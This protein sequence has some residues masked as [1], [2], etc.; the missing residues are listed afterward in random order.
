MSWLG[1]SLSDY[2]SPSAPVLYSL[3]AHRRV[4]SEAVPGA[5]FDSELEG[6]VTGVVQQWG[7]VTKTN[8]VVLLV[9]I[10]SLAIRGTSA[11][12]L[13]G[14]YEDFLDAR[15]AEGR[16]VVPVTITP[17]G[18]YVS[19][20]AG[21]KAD[22]LT[23]NAALL[24][25]C[26]ANPSVSSCVDLYSLMDDGTGALKAAYDSGDHVHFTQAGYALYAQS[27]LTAAR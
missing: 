18:G 14:Y 3:A 12:T 2:G 11:A 21:V 1:D 15:V 20:T 8:R 10:N 22:I 25:W 17:C 9:G 16:F 26:A 5:S 13:W 4:D 23:V 27:I 7:T 6:G 24:A 19:C